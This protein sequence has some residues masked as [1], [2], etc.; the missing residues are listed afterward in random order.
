M[1]KT[2]R[3][4]SNYSSHINKCL[5]RFTLISIR[6]SRLKS[7]AHL[8]HARNACKCIQYM[9]NTVVLFIMHSV[10]NRCARSVSVLFNF[11]LGTTQWYTL[12]FSYFCINHTI[13]D[14]SR[15][16]LN[17]LSRFTSICKGILLLETARIAFY[18]HFCCEMRNTICAK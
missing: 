16:Y 5:K 11:S 4:T 9:S 15:I 14:V 6:N 17:R 2:S 12:T 10:E 1:K 3:D 13:H 8:Y 7:K 18:F